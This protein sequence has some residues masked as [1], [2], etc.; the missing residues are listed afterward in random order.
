MTKEV[1]KMEQN[2]CLETSHILSPDAVPFDIAKN[3]LT[4]LY[5]I[6]RKFILNRSNRFLLKSEQ[7]QTN[8]L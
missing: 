1:V 6:A 4:V 3:R 5:N 7:F 2:Q 8:R